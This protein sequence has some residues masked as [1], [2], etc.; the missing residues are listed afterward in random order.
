MFLYRRNLY[1]GD[2][3]IPAKPYKLDP[4]YAQTAKRHDVVKLN[5]EG[6]VVGAAAGDTT[7]LG[8]LETVEIK[9][10]SETDTYGAVRLSRGAVYEARPSAAGAVVGDKYGITALGATV[11]VADTTTVAVEVVAIRDNGNIDVVLLDN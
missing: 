4:T 3:V 8:V 2:T 1:S 7:I 9:M 6:N 5:A 11:E 10:E